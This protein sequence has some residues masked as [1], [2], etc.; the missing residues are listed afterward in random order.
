MQC[1][2]AGCMSGLAN[3]QDR[4]FQRWSHTAL[5]GVQQGEPDRY[6]DMPRLGGLLGHV[7]K[8]SPPGAIDR[9]PVSVSLMAAPARQQAAADIPTGSCR[10]L[11]EFRFVWQSA[12]VNLV[13]VRLHMGHHAS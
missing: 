4:L 11:E 13:G 2:I 3:T 10:V 12:C 8:E 1:L 9:T 6:F 5:Q 7:M